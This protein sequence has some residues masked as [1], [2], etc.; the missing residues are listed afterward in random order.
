[1][2][3]L[4]T[5]LQ[6]LNLPN[7]FPIEDGVPG[8]E[9]CLEHP[10]AIQQ[11][12]ATSICWIACWCS[13]NSSSPGTHL[14]MEIYFEECFQSKIL[15]FNNPISL[16]CNLQLPDCLWGFQ[17]FFFTRNTIFYWKYIWKIVSKVEFWYVTT[18]PL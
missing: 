5:K 16:G 12:V 17:T 14:L 1:M 8:E 4:H 3:L 15:V 2:G 10:Q 7:L 11:L 13:K 18:R 6:L 9:E